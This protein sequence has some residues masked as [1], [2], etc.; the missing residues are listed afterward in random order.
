[1][2]PRLTSAPEAAYPAGATGDAVVLLTVT[3]EAD[4]SVRSAQVTTGEEPFASAA[5]D[6]VRRFV[7]EPATR[8]G[9]PVAATIRFEISFHAPEPPPPE[10]EQTSGTNAENKANVPQAPIEV[11]VRGTA[12]AP[13]V[14]SFSRAEVRQL[15]GAFGDPFRAIEALPGVT[16]IAS[17]LPFFYVRGAPPGNVGYFLD[18]VR[19]PY[20]Y[21]VGLGPSIVHPG[22]V[23]RVDLYPGGYPAR[24]GRYAGGI[25]AGET[26]NP[27][28]EL[29]GEANLRLFDVGVLAET[30]FDGGRGSI[31]LGG[32]YSY[33]A[34]VVSLLAPEVDL[35]YR[36]YQ[37]RVSYQL[38]PDDRLTA[39]GFGAYDL[40]AET[41]NGIYT[42]V[43]GTEFYRLDL[44]YDHSFA[45]ESQLRTAITLGF[46]QTHL[47]EQGQNARDRMLS[48]RSELYHPLASSV[49][50]RAGADVTLDAFSRTSRMQYV[51]PDNPNVDID[52]D[53]NRLFPTRTDLAFGAWT[54]L[55]WNPLRH[56][57][58]TA[59]ARVDRFASG[60]QTALSVD[61]RVAARF[62]ITDRLRITHAYGLA[63]QPPS[64]VVPIP[65]LTPGKL[66]GGLQTS[67]QTSAGVELDLFESTTATATLFH[68][69]FFNMNDALGAP[70][71]SGAALDEGQDEDNLE[72]ALDQRS[73][74]TSQGFELFVRRRLTQRLGGYL[75]YTLSRSTRTVN[76]YSFPSAFDR[77]HVGSTALAYDLGRSWRAGTRFVFYTGIPK[78]P[79]SIVIGENLIRPPPLEHP[80]RDPPFYR[81]DVRLEK[82]WTFGERTWISF[83]L[84][85]LN[86]TLQK[87]TFGENQVGP[88]TIPSIGLEAGF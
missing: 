20:L 37:V 14:S 81:L 10:P 78:E 24:F 70:D 44:R 2:P 76:R 60:G 39:F 27:E 36:D 59:G 16:P 33:T 83:V 72:A 25:V 41:N 4:G 62:E 86:A 71:A 68:N 22:M 35:A 6:A 29:H 82:R 56:V 1:M 23:E 57:E 51:D 75:S 85:V 61:P 32:R 26:T 80:E 87:E 88:V 12:L 31:L 54:D 50:L 42:V 63:H 84:E 66:S 69:A 55:V 43:F 3:V 67:F 18:G 9:Q 45:P 34:A 5:L 11:L 53:F 21:H 58:V 13:A 49:T 64:F 74:G 65:G 19:V 77:T 15:P 48:L 52:F 47:E 40:L 46:D 30:G 38:T 8:D 73:R 7:F 28:S 17:G 79:P